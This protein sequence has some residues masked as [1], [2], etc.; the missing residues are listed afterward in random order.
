MKITDVEIEN[1][2]AIGEA[3]LSLDTLGLAHIAGINNDETSADSNGSGKSSLPDAISWCLWGT[4][5]R[6]LS[7][8]DIIN[9]P[10]GKGA[11]A[12]VT[13]DDDGDL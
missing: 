8:D 3:K 6:G 12:R 1:V 4:T 10:A 9:T 11:A 5:A 7:G 13:I 2:L